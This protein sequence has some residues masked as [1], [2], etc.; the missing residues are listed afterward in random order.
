MCLL[1]NTLQKFFGASTSNVSHG[2]MN[3]SVSDALTS[4]FAPR[5]ALS[6]RHVVCISA[7][8]SFPL[9]IPLGKT[10]LTLG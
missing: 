3:P 8:D 4:C 10:A 5:W 7:L 6:K 2:C 1:Q 9:G